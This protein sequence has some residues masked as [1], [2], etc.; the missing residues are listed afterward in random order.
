MNNVVQLI[1]KIKTKTVCQVCVD[2]YGDEEYMLG[3]CC[4]LPLFDVP[5]NQADLANDRRMVQARKRLREEAS[6]LDW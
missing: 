5:M 1:P 2:S 3:R 6:K 4:G